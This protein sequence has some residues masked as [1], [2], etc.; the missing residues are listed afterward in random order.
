M[1]VVGVSIGTEECVA[2]RGVEEVRNAGA[3]CPTRFLAGMLDKQAVTLIA[4][5]FFGPRTSYLER[6]ADT[7]MPPEACRRADTGL[8]YGS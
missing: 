5:E 4:T 6:V 3:D 8:Q 7:G 2:K 1:T